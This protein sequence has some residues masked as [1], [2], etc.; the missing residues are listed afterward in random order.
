MSLRL[1]KNGKWVYDFWPNGSK[2]KHVR[3]TLP[4][5][6]KTEEQAKQFAQKFRHIYQFKPR[7]NHIPSMDDLFSLAMKY[8]AEH[9]DH[10][11]YKELCNSFKSFLQYFKT[12]NMSEA[13]CLEPSPTV[14]EYFVQDR[15]MTVSSKTINKELAHFNK[16]HSFW[17]SQGYCIP[18][19]FELTRF[20]I[21]DRT[22]RKNFSEKFY[23]LLIERFPVQF[24]GKQ[25]TFI[26]K[27]PVLNK[28]LPDS[29][30]ASADGSFVVVEIQK[31]RLDRTH[32]YKILEYRDKL[33][34]CLV[35]DGS[36]PNIAMMV[37]VIGDICSAER[38]EFLDKYGI[39]LVILPL[40]QIE[41]IILN[42]LNPYE[43]Q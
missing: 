33:E 15:S 19:G 27:P 37:V 31:E 28:L 11:K 20:Y 35:K 7:L 17:C 16:L 24:I 38:K 30:F 9:E 43:L 1:K 41:E 36:I 2:G 5:N 42:L 3:K 6:I 39:E 32:A 12:N 18:L 25:L 34:K 4:V 22:V 10:T 26:D 8:F 29:L 23:E 13:D 14:I 40:Q 21:K